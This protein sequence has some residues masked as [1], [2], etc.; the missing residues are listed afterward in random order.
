LGLG[1]QQVQDRFEPLASKPT[2]V[3]SAEK[4]PFRTILRGRLLSCAENCPQSLRMQGNFYTASTGA[5]I[6]NVF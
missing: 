4:L 6:P 3:I 1:P 5:K 2:R